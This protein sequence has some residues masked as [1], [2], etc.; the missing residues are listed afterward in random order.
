[1]VNSFLSQFALCF[2]FVFQ[3][4]ETWKV[5]FYVSHVLYLHSYGHATI[6]AAC[7]ETEQYLQWLKTW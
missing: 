6:A 7:S 3:L 2:H 4:S 5:S 1:M